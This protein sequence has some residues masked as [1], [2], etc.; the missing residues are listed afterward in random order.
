MICPDCNG[1]GKTIASHVRYADGRGAFNVPVRCIRCQGKG[2]VADR[3]PQWIEA[4][5]RMKTLRMNAG[6]TLR[7]EA[8]RRG[9]DAALLSAMEFGRAEP[10]MEDSSESSVPNPQS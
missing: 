8:S 6:R 7:E 3:T 2:H 9:M 10:K 5:A 1:E 4:G